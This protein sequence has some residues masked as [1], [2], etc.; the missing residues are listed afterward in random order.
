MKKIAIIMASLVVVAI[1]NSCSDTFLERPPLGATFEDVFYNEKGVDA[2]LTGTYA[3]VKGSALW[4]VSWGASIQNW[5]YGSVASDDAYK[6]SEVTDQVP[7]NEIERW[8]VTTT[9][10]YPAE[11]WRLNIG[12]G[13]DRAN[14]TLRILKVCEEKGTVSPEKATQFRAELRFLRGLFYFESWLVFGDYIPLIDENVPDPALVSNDNQKGAVLNFI[15][16]DL[17]YAWENLPASQALIGRPTKYAAMALAARAYLQE[18]KYDEAKP[19]LDNIINSKKYE[20][21]PKFIDNFNI[22][23][24]NNKESIFEIQACVNDINESLNAEMGIGLNFPHGGDIG[25]CCG[26]HQ[27]SQNLVNAFKVDDNGLPLFDTFNDE[28]LK[29]DQGLESSQYFVQDTVTPVDPRLDFTVGRR[30]IPYKDW[31]IMR[32]SNWIRK[33][34]EGGPYLP[35]SKPFFKKSQ[36]YKLSTTTGWQTGVNANNYRYLRY[37]HVLLWRAEIAAYEGD[38]ATALDCINQVR[39]RAGKDVVM[40]R[41]RIFELPV[42][43]YPWGPETTDADYQ[44]GGKV[45]WD[46]PAANYKVSPY[47]AF[48][49]KEEAMRAAQWEQRLEFATEGRRFF[50][51]RR[52]DNLPESMKVDMVKTLNDFASADLR[53][54][55]FMKGANFSNKDKFMPVP[56]TQLDLQPGVLVQNPDYR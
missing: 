13:V 47:T 26:F 48:A 1:I 34:S 39:E 31:G 49:N 37:S 18:L 46:V 33:Q 38:L 21:M 25:M 52:W 11:K 44:Q 2:L 43:V 19:L 9:N 29:N 23:T 6:G 53:I 51:L 8:E 16:S 42:A 54:R 55:D 4:T 40:G 24:E 15:I 22:E 17:Q 35:A 12:M 3:M 45:A 14:K 32:G 30:G 7:V 10:N 5:T 56:Q 36:R 27:P 41:V 50:D 28:D 20:L